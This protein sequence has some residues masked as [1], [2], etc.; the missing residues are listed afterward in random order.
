MGRVEF[1]QGAAI[2]IGPAGAAPGSADF[3]YDDFVLRQQLVQLPGL[4][5]HVGDCKVGRHAA[6]RQLGRKA[7]DRQGQ[8]QKNYP[9][10]VHVFLLNLSG[11]RNT[12]L[13][14]QNYNGIPGAS[15]YLCLKF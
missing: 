1:L 10:V 4:A 11:T 2:M 3:Q 7:T 13:D 12:D 15:V 14:S 9:T 8:H 5:G 6:R